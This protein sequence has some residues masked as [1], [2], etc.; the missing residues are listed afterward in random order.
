MSA[1][2]RQLLSIALVA[3]GLA[4]FAVEF[5]GAVP[6]RAW[7][8]Y[9]IN[10]LLF[11][12]IAQGALLFSALMHT[13]GARWP[14]VLAELAEAFAGFFPV[15]L[16]LFPPLY[17]GREH[18]F[19]WLHM[20]LPHGK[21]A[22]L[23]LPFLMSRD[24]AALS[25][26]Y[27]LGWAYRHRAARLRREPPAAHD[28][29]LA[30]RT[31]QLAILYM[32]AFALVLSLIGYDL[33]MAAD[34]HWFST[35]FGAYSFIKAIYLGFGA[36]IILAA[37]LHLNPASG[38]VISQGQFHDLGKLFFAFCLVWADF[39][40]AQLV[41]IW[42]GNIP[43]ETS[44][45]IART[46][47]PP[48]NRLAWVVFLVCFMAP[49]LVLLNRRVKTIPAAMRVF[50]A[51]IIAGLW[52]EHLLLLGPSL[53]SGATGIELGL[54]EVL[55]TAGFSGLMAL[56]VGKTLARRLEMP[57]DGHGEVAA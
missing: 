37:S 4:A 25:L 28:Q 51:L 36:L 38:V 24:F 27:G 35:L 49:F 8:A 21:E 18:L 42:Y 2:Q 44:Y 1:R 31:T 48:W 13:V 53:N 11:S 33:V 9:L 43:E 23:N 10:F 40:Y 57:A 46:L 19:P 7:Q 41:V 29:R 17:F 52:L 16:A 56:A 50:C 26:L 34:P 30:R 6:G 15:S 55:M 39:F 32:L 20:A 5:A 12:A 45:V 22:W 14:G 54:P 3:C 47:L